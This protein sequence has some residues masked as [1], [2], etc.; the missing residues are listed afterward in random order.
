MTEAFQMPFF[1][2]S[3]KNL[4]VASSVVRSVGLCSQLVNKPL[5][6]GGRQE[7]CAGYHGDRQAVGNVR[8]LSLMRF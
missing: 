2:G 7:A 3:S 8:C 6:Q 5:R 4:W 1:S